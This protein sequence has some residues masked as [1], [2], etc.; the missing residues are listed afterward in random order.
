MYF[1]SRSRRRRTAIVRGA[2]SVDEPQLAYGWQAFA[3]GYNTTGAA[4][5]R[6]VGQY[7]RAARDAA[8]AHRGRALSVARQFDAV[9]EGRWIFLAAIARQDGKIVFA[10]HGLKYDKLGC[11]SRVGH[12]GSPPGDLCQHTCFATRGSVSF[13]TRKYD[14][15]WPDDGECDAEN[16]G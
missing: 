7:A 11:E 3:R 2:I 10:V 5:G 4:S 9:D 14:F 13:V 6:K 1:A 15:L 8:A 12:G 16:C